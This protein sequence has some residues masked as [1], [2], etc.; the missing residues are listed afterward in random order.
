MELGPSRRP[1]M[2]GEP[3]YSRGELTDF[4][5]LS[6]NHNTLS[7]TLLCKICVAPA[8]PCSSFRP[9]RRRLCCLT[10][11]TVFRFPKTFSIS[12]VYPDRGK[13]QNARRERRKNTCRRKCTT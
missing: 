2:R 4:Q 10:R 13:R 9:G 5:L 12:L 11:V 6:R 3:A 1:A 8:A 7:T